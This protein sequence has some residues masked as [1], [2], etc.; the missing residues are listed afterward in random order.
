LMI[1]VGWCFDQLMPCKVR[2]SGSRLSGDW[3]VDW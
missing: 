3:E 2:F 1:A